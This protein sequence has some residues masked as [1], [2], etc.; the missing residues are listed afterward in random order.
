MIASLSHLEA[1]CLNVTL[2]ALY[3][4]CLFQN[5]TAKSNDTYQRETLS[6]RPIQQPFSL[7]IMSP[8]HTEICGVMKYHQMR[9]FF[10]DSRILYCEESTKL[11]RNVIVVDFQHYIHVNS[12]MLSSE[13]D[14]KLDVHCKSTAPTLWL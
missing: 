12:R 11:V 4:N 1:L 10:M 8:V 7:S 14:T 9:A 13:D 3:N 5:K 2:N 6:E